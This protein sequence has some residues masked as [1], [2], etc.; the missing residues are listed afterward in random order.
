MNT[1]TRVTPAGQILTVDLSTDPPPAYA[2]SAVTERR[3]QAER[4]HYSLHSLTG[5]VTQP[6]RIKGRR[7][8]D[9]RFAVLDHF[10]SGVVTL[11]ILLMCLSV[12]DSVLTLT[13]IARG[14][15]EVNPFMN[16]LLQHSIWLFTAG[17]MMLTAVPV[18]LLVATGNLL[19]RGRLRPR[20]LLGVLAGLYLGLIAYEILLLNFG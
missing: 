6:R 13:L 7:R 12:L 15:S 14:G 11:A 9:R 16:Y 17:K 18:I 5:A 10:D 3:R 2:R 1:A 19:I 8:E 20:S 4:R